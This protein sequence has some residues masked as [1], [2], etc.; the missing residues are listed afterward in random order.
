[1]VHEVRGSVWHV[2]GGRRRCGLEIEDGTRRLH[3]VSDG[4]AL[5]LGS[6]LLVLVPFLGLSV[7]RAPPVGQE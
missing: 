5:V 4:D 7:E 2:R 3:G 1:L 6:E